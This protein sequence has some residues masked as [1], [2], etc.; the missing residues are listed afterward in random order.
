MLTRLGTASAATQTD[1][2]GEGCH[3]F[4]KVAAK[5]KIT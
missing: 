2:S 4:A 1:D 5:T 3:L